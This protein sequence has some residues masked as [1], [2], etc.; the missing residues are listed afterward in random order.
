MY[1]FLHKLDI[2]L[3]EFINHLPHTAFFDII[4][5]FLWQYLAHIIVVLSALFWMILPKK[6][7]YI[8]VLAMAIFLFTALFNQ[9]FLKTVFHRY[10]PYQKIPSTITVFSKLED[11]SFPSG[12]A[13]TVMAYSTVFL[14]LTKNRKI[15]YGLLIFTVIIGLDRI[16]MGHHYP[17]DVVAGIISGALIGV[18]GSKIWQN[19]MRLKCGK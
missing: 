10:R 16:Y 2:A 14:I 18:L 7:K 17:W 3:F 5:T 9:Y 1:Q 19:R 4:A 11:Y 8:P 15:K 13:A 12:H 6:E